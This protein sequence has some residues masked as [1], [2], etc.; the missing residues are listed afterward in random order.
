MTVAPKSASTRVVNGPAYTHVVSSTLIPSRGR[1]LDGSP[2]PSRSFSAASSSAERGFAL[3][4]AVWAPR[5]GGV[6]RERSGVRLGLH[7]APGVI[8]LPHAGS[9]TVSQ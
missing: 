9:A 1:G 7:H 5:S 3:M 2:P 6:P 8:T 4:A